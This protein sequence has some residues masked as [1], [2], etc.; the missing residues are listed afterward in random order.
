LP[1]SACRMG[2]IL[3]TRVDLFE[4]DDHF[5]IY[6]VIG[7]KPPVLQIRPRLASGSKRRPGATQCLPVR[8]WA[9]AKAR[10]SV[11]SPWRVPDRRGSFQ[12]RWRSRRNQVKMPAWH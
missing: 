9:A 2:S 1:C 8:P 10:Q 12:L 6:A 4:L 5:S 7:W 3:P 11:G